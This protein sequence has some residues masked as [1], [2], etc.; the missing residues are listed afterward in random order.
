MFVR[1]IN[2]LYSVYHSIS[3]L[4]ILQCS[5]KKSINVAA[6]QTMMER[7]ISQNQP[8]YYTQT[9]TR[10]VESRIFRAI[11]CIHTS[12]LNLSILV[13][14]KEKGFIHGREVFIDVSGTFN[15]SHVNILNYT[16]CT[17]SQAD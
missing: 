12:A 17:L 8:L 4:N 13:F 7:E 2:L 11:L 9:E 10:F 3:F 6:Y 16:I 1:T 15:T 5:N 14:E